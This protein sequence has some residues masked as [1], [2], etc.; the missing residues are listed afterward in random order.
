MIDRP[1]AQDGPPGIRLLHTVIRR[2]L[3][4][5]VGALGVGAVTVHAAG[6]AGEGVGTAHANVIAWILA[7]TAVVVAHTAAAL[8][9]RDDRPLRTV[10]WLS[11]VGSVAW[12]AG[13]VYRLVDPS[14]P[15]PGIFLLDLF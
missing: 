1:G 11:A 12:L 9:V 15:S 13:A 2:P 7:A 8:R 10:W 3:V 5:L 14:V 6:L 4:L